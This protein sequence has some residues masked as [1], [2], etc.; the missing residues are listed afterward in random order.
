MAVNESRSL[1]KELLEGLSDGLVSKSAPNRIT[2]EPN[3]LYPDSRFEGGYNHGDYRAVDY[4]YD[5]GLRRTGS[6]AH[7]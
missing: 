4:L 1:N 5:G 2:T 6:P 7:R 3:R